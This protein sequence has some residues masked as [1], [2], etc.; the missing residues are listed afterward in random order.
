MEPTAVVVRPPPEQP[1]Q[2]HGRY[3]RMHVAHHPGECGDDGA[4]VRKREPA[5]PG[6]GVGQAAAAGGHGR[7]P[8]HLVP[9]GAPR[10]G[11]NG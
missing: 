3:G 2:S 7:E 6:G 11:T 8:D 4:R 9:V 5:I 1:L 10:A